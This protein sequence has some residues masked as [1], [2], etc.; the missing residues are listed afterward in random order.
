MGVDQFQAQRS[1]LLLTSYRAFILSSQSVK[2]GWRLRGNKTCR[3][4][5]AM[6]SCE[7]DL[8]GPVSARPR[9]G[10]PALHCWVCPVCRE[11]P[12]EGE[13]G[14]SSREEGRRA[15]FSTTCCGPCGPESSKAPS[16]APAPPPH[17]HQSQGYVI[18]AGLYQA[19]NWNS[20]GQLKPKA[21]RHWPRAGL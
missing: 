1:S 17:T 19:A 14:G 4:L 5:P 20:K 7:V 10:G 18:P 8:P 2:Y 11:D 12:G 16:P 6:A 3:P 15:C 9:A 13:A 21:Q